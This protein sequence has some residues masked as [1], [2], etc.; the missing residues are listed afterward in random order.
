MKY[1]KYLAKKLLNDESTFEIR[2]Y[3]NNK[4]LN[5]GDRA[6]CPTCGALFYKRNKQHAFCRARCKDVFWSNMVEERFKRK[7]G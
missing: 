7:I 6:V 3:S 2:R 4:E 5:A 1:D